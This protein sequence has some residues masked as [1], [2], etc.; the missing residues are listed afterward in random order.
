MKEFKD[1]QIEDFIDMGSFPKQEMCKSPSRGGS[2]RK[3]AKGYPAIPY[4]KHPVSNLSDI[5]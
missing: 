1:Y 5:L 4:T 2:L 3:V